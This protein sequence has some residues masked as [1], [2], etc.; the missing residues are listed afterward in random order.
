M[1]AAAAKSP[2][3]E[4]DAPPSSRERMIEAAIS[5]LRAT[6]LTGAGINQ[7]IAA[8]GA[9]KG[10]MY[11]H[12]PGGKLELAGVALERWGE[13][14]ARR[15]AADLQGPAPLPRKV[16]GIF[17]GTARTM[18]K[19]DYTRSC[20]IGAVSLDLDEESAALAPVCARIFAS[21]HAVL[22]EAMHEIPQ[23]RRAMLA[24][25]V[26][27]SIQGAQVQ[28]RAAHDNSCILEAGEMVAAMIAHALKEKKNA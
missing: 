8:S 19:A 13:A 23:P 3:K 9:P 15:I 22:E 5:L 1:N 26:I 17:E 6:G 4:G 11:H 7:V 21:W 27:S 16:R 18:A 12:F 2:P 10:S 28:A 24:R 20:G 14:V 25:F